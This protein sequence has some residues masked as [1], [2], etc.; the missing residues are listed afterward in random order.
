MADNKNPNEP[1]KNSK[2]NTIVSVFILILFFIVG[3]IFAN[4]GNG[5]V[6]D[7]SFIVWALGIILAFLN[8]KKNFFKLK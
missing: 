1:V 4:D 2:S 6:R 3:C 7:C 5:T 8:Q